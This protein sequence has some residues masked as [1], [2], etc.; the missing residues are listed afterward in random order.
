MILFNIRRLSWSFVE[1]TIRGVLFELV[2]LDVTKGLRQ[3]ISVGGKRMVQ[4]REDTVRICPRNI[5]TVCAERQRH[6]RRSTCA[7]LTDVFG[8]PNVFSNTHD[9]QTQVSLDVFVE[10]TLEIIT[11][12]LIIIIA[13]VWLLTQQRTGDAVSDEDNNIFMVDIADLNTNSDSLWEES[14]DRLTLDLHDSARA[15]RSTST[16]K[17]TARALAIFHFESTHR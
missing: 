16:R 6:E 8:H 2:C 10:D 9:N 7:T 11:N 3:C 17:T 15:A 13:I 5:F 12:P 4:L 14:V 1:G